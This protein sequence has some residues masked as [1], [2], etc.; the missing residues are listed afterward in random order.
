MK[1]SAGS[2]LIIHQELNSSKNSGTPSSGTGEKTMRINFEYMTNLQYK[3]KALQAQ[4]DAF[5]SGEA[6][7]RQKE[8]YEKRLREKDRIIAALKKELGRSHAETITMR[9]RWMEVFE[10]LEKEHRKA[11]SKEQKKTARMEQRI[12]A[13]EKSEDR[14]HEKWKKQQVQLY[15]VWTELEEEKEKNRKLTA[16]VNKDFENS[17]IPSSM[18]GMGRKKIPNSRVKTGKRPGGQPGHKGHRRKLHVP[19]E[20]HELPA[21]KK[22]QDSPDYYETGKVVRKQKV[23]IHLGVRII[24]YTTKEYR[25]RRTGARVHA[26]FPAG[27]ENEVNYGGS[28]KALAFL[29]GNECNVS[30][31][32]IRKLIEELTEGEIRLSD[33]MI[34]GLCREFSAKTKEEKQEIIKS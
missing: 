27:Y 17:S 3:V 34:N 10:D 23:E 12:L 8:E 5:Q 28:V 11:M 13:A 21:P 6:Y 19:T 31:G 20:T 22:Y 4:V 30:H 25:D 26:P 14:W 2:F 24:E 9:D 18:Q 33:G 7:L 1:N 15:A 29:L 16:Q 32:K